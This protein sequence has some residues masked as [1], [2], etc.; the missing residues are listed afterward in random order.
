MKKKI[1]KTLSKIPPFI[2]NKYTLTLFVFF[3]WMLFFDKNDIISTIKLKL[4]LSDLR[5]QK[6]YYQKELKATQELHTAIFNKD[7]NLEK[8]ARE[9][10][11]MKRDNEMLY[12]SVEE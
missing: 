8:F 4:Q 7:E 5:D 2:R 3:V 10:F 6:E 11:Y 9:K 1:S 12:V